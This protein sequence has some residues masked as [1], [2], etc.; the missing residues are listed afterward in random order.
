MIEVK[1]TPA[2]AAQPDRV[3]AAVERKVGRSVREYRVVRRSIDARKGAV[4][5]TEIRL[6][7]EHRRNSTVEVEARDQAGRLTAF[8]RTVVR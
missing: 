4:A 5:A 3:L 7:Q 8:R 1:L 6:G 2:E